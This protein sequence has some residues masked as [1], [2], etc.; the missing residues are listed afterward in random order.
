MKRVQAAQAAGGKVIERL[1]IGGGGKGL[2]PVEK[3]LGI[4]ADRGTA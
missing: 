2:A 1:A 4:N 3:R